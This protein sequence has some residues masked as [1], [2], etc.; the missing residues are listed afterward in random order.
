MILYLKQL[1]TLKTDFIRNDNNTKIW[2]HILCYCHC[3]L[4]SCFDFSSNISLV[5]AGFWCVQLRLGKL[6]VQYLYQL[7]TTRL[8]YHLRFKVCIWWLKAWQFVRDSRCVYYLSWFERLINVYLFSDNRVTLTTWQSSKQL[9][10]KYILQ[11]VLRTLKNQP[12]HT[13]D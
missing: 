11:K 6:R 5:N 4:F 2:H 13:K 3:Q 1:I 8:G 7:K 12:H 9:Q 10:T